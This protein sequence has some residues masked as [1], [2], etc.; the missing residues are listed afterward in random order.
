M[1]IRPIPAGQDGKITWGVLGKRVTY[2]NQAFKEVPNLSPE[3]RRQQLLEKA[4]PYT[5]DDYLGKAIVVGGGGV[6]DTTATPTPSMTPTPTITSTSTPTPT[7]TPSATPGPSIDPDYQALLNYATS[8]GY[9]LPSASGQTLQNDLVVNLKADGIWGDLDIFYVMATDGDSSFAKLNWINPS[10]HTLT[11]VGVM[12]FVVNEGF[13]R[14]A[15]G[16][17]LDTNYNT[18]TD[19]I[20]C[21]ITGTT[22]FVWD[23]DNKT[24]SRR[25]YM[26]HLAA[27][28]LDRFNGEIIT[29]SQSINGGVDPTT[30]Q[31]MSGVGFK[32]L[33]RN[34]TDLYYYNNSGTSFTNTNVGTGGSLVNENLLLGRD[35]SGAGN[36][37]DMIISIAG[38]GGSLSGKE[39]ALFSTF[40]TYMTNL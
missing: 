2:K 19:A 38:R 18:S 31:D 32:M 25:C 3:E 15:G 7:P 1:S 8:Q 35:G 11:E 14:A 26:G 10:A 33:Q 23:F 12:T 36:Q 24:A 28:G 34:G 17:Y 29:S 20:N 9:T 40:G 6:Y 4:K 27:G 16:T 30:G 5:S 21:V 22:Q 37:S 13:D 39:S